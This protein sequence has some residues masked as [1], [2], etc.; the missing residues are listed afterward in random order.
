MRKG[1]LPLLLLIGALGC[2]ADGGRINLLRSSGPTHPTVAAADVSKEDL[3]TYLNNVSK[4]IPGIQSDDIGL[5]CYTGGPVGLPVSG[6]L[7]AQ[8]PRNFRMTAYAL[9]DQEVDLGSNNQEFWYWI[10]RAEPNAQVFCSY[11]AI[12]E[13]RVK[14]MPFPFQPDWVLEAMGMGNYGPPE[15]YELV[16]EDKHFKLIEKTRSP[17]GVPVKKIIVF[18]R[19]KVPVPQPQITDFLCVEEATNKGALL[20]PYH[21]AANHRGPRR[22]ATGAGAALAGA[23]AEA[24]ATSEQHPAEWTDRPAILCAGRSSGTFRPMTSPRVAWKACSRRAG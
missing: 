15:K 6:K 3:V 19:S 13:G 21:T 1:L 4:A 2:S 7:R 12:E 5:T 8:G 22:V 23:K 10:R 16:V 20:R 11:Q 24:G 14:Q 18:N 9:G 17:Q